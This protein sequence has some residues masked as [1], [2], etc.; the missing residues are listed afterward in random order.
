MRFFELIILGIWLL[1]AIFYLPRSIVYRDLKSLKF[2]TAAFVMQN[3]ICALSG[4]FFGHR[5]TQFLILY[6]EVI[7]YGV[8]FIYVFYIKKGKISFNLLPLLMV[9]CVLFIY[10][11]IGKATIYTKLICFRQ[12]MTPV[13]LIMYGLCLKINSY[14]Q[15]DYIKFCV[16]FGVIQAI[17]GIFELFVL[18]DEFWKSI[19]IENIMAA[20]G[21]S[22]WVYHGLPGD[23]YSGDFYHIIGRS[24]RRLVGLTTDPLL[25]AHYLAFCFVILLFHKVYN[26][27]LKQIFALILLSITVFF[28]LSKGAILIMA[29]SFMCRTWQKQ[30]IVAITLIVPIIVVLMQIINKNLLASVSVHV[31]GLTS[32]LMGI[33]ILGNGLGSA[34]NFANYYGNTSS[35]GE[36][37]VG[38]ILGQTGIIGLCIFVYAIIYTSKRVVYLNKNTLSF[39]V[40]VYIFACIIEAFVSESAIN[41]VGSGIAFIILGVL[42]TKRY[43]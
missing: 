36:S 18:G 20:K 3:M 22:N 30:K 14:D 5:L 32:S 19:H 38:L 23:Y 6:K 12:I 35:I 27:Q 29:I 4:L 31:G 39:S 26:S 41:Y 9:T 25:T 15:E 43:K 21:F 24:V 8:V 11:F 40:V 37:Y 1:I 34:G 13:I 16:N 42:S 7:L 28:T 2:L 33:S 10:F 17:F